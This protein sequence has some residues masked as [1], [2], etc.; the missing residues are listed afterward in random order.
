VI[1]FIQRHS[2]LLLATLLCALSI[3]HIQRQISQEQLL[4]I[5]YQ[6]SIAELQQF[7]TQLLERKP[8]MNRR[9]LMQARSDANAY[10]LLIYGLMENYYDNSTLGFDQHVPKNPVDFFF[11]I[12]AFEKRMREK[13]GLMGVRY[14]TDISF[15][16][17]DFIRKD[18]TPHKG[19]LKDLWEQAY[20]MEKVL[21]LL[22]S[23]Q[24]GGM[25]LVSAKREA[26]PSDSNQKGEENTFKMDLFHRLSSKKGKVNSVCLQ[27]VFEDYTKTLRNFINHMRKEQ[28]PI[29]LRGLSVKPSERLEPKDNAK[30]IVASGYS[31]ITLT[32]EWLEFKEQAGKII[33]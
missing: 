18:T 33:K 29:V 27:I 14:S 16:F 13:A 22:F 12:T 7:K 3:V 21:M 20:A 17:S 1:K 4:K 10:E 32:L 28:L 19:A 26:L 6:K 9:T 8:P 15:G 31:R 11:A 23:S 24:D 30:V 5:H 25:N 2:F